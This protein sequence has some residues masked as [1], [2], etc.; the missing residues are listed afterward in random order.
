MK[1]FMTDRRLKEIKGQEYTKGFRQGENQERAHP[2]YTV[3]MRNLDQAKRHHNQVI[4]LEAQVL[5]LQEHN[6]QLQEWID[7]ES[8]D[9][10][11]HG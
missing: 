8:I 3:D 2:S 5:A 1:L 6:Q 4:R 7:N 11:G 10:M 9:G